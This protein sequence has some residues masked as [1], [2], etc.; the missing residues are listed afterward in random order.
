M[1]GEEGEGSEGDEGWD[2]PKLERTFEGLCRFSDVWADEWLFQLCKRTYW[3]AEKRGW[4][5]EDFMWSISILRMNERKCWFMSFAIFSSLLFV[6][7]N[8]P[9]F[10]RS[11]SLIW[12]KSIGKDEFRLIWKERTMLTSNH[13]AL[14]HGCISIE[15]FS[16]ST[17]DGGYLSIMAE[18]NWDSSCRAMTG[19]VLWRDPSQC[20]RT[21]RWQ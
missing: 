19:Q 8:Q 9:L 11:S 21:P 7:C 2:R 6:E 17:P 10:A 12:S 3:A 14:S 4:G 1:R 13:S 20:L 18:S 5:D 15:Y 16:M